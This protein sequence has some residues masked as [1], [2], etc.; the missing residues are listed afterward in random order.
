MRSSLGVIRLAVG[1]VSSLVLSI[2]GGLVCVCRATSNRGDVGVF[3]GTNGVNRSGSDGDVVCGWNG[4]VPRSGSDGEGLF[5]VRR[6]ETT[7]VRN[8]VILVCLYFYFW[9][10]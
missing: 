7:I 8:S 1:S 4:V 6:V 10:G 9:D 3:V 5:A 2:L